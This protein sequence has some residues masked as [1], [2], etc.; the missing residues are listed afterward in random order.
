ME[1]PLHLIK[2]LEEIV[3]EAVYSLSFPLICAYE[4]EKMPDFL[5]NSL[6][7]THPYVLLDDD[8]IISEQYQSS[9]TL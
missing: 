8:F 7:E 4:G 2:D 6:M 9:K 5:N 1:E 3:D